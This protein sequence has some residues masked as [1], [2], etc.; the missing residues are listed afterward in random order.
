M[1]GSR[2]RTRPRRHSRRC[3]SRAVRGT[4]R[5]RRGDGHDRLERADHPRGRGRPAWSSVRRPPAGRLPRRIGPAP[6]STSCRSP[7]GAI[8]R[9]LVEAPAPNFIFDSWADS[10]HDAVF[11][12][13]ATETGIEFHRIGIDGSGDQIVATV[14]PDSTGF[15]AE[16]ALDHSAFV[17]DACHVGAG[18]ARTIVDPA[19]GASERDGATRATRCAAIYGIVDGTLVGTTRPVCS[20]E[21]ATDVVA[22]PLDGGD[23]VV[24]VEDFVGDALHQGDAR[25]DERRPQARPG[26]AR[27]TGCHALGCHR[28]RDPR[29]GVLD[30]DD[31][32]VPLS[33]A[34][35]VPLPGGWVMLHGAGGLGD[36]PWQRAIDRPVPIIVNLVTG[37]RI[38]L[39]NLPHWTG[40]LSVSP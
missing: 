12:G 35:D 30:E 39:V 10:T 22:I 16:L 37:E 15:T 2:R 5:Q 9:T 29:D 31:G 34:T 18:C 7:S 40:T 27:R 33:V 23:P 8:D 11:Y 21:S 28:H 26:R 19:S 13:I 32:D 6:T 24:V 3:R 20:T 1:P 17:V 14:A 25:G 4:R 36:F 38:E